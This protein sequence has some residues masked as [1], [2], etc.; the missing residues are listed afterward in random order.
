MSNFDIDFQFMIDNEDR[1]QAHAC[2]PDACPSGCSG[3]CYAIS[4]IN[5]GAYPTQFA[6]IAATPQAQRGPAVESF[7]QK[8]FFNQYEA[9]LSDPVEE[10]ILDAKVN[11]GPV[12]GCKFLQ[13]AINSVTGSGTVTV[14][15]QWGPATVAAAN[16]CDQNALVSAIQATRK[17]YYLAIVAAH[18]EDS[19]Y[20]TGWL[21]RAGE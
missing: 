4:G 20:E 8:E 19:K 2:N 3:P 6:A 16:A 5:S 12:T 11:N 18:P 15:G 17:A 7:Y 14:D 21:A 1:T 13:E 10:R 9:Q